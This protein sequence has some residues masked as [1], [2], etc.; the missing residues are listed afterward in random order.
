MHRFLIFLSSLFI[1]LGV[2]AQA[3]SRNE[4]DVGSSIDRYAFELTTSKAVLSGVM[5]LKIDEKEIK[6]SLINEFGFSALSFIYDREKNK[7]KLQDV[8]SFLNKWYIKAVLK[9]DL[10]ICLSQLYNFP[11]KIEKKYQI[12]KENGITIINNTKYHITYSFS[13]LNYNST[14]NEF[15]E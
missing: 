5:I 14:E 13:P 9:N 7:I 2:K 3:V 8:I 1:F 11:G 12:E 10:K 4:N 6:G 15:R